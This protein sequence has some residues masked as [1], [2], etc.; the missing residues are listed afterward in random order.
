MLTAG[1]GLQMAAIP[2]RQQQ[3]SLHGGEIQLQP[4][5]QRG[6]GPLAQAAGGGMMT[7]VLVAEECTGPKG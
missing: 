1:L 6:T 7:G 5:S 2:L 4:W 3:H